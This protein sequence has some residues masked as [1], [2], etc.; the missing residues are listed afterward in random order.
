[1][2]SSYSYSLGWIFFLFFFLPNQNQIYYYNFEENE[3]D[4]HKQTTTTKT[5]Q[6]KPFSRLL[7]ILFTLYALCGFFCITCCNTHA[8]CYSECEKPYW[9]KNYCC[10]RVSLS[11]ALNTIAKRQISIMFQIVPFPWKTF[12]QKISHQDCGYELLNRLHYDFMMNC[13]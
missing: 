12:T 9:D 7:F 6:I 11:N 5:H 4:E 13:Y 2:I 10:F 3:I 8:Q 1:M